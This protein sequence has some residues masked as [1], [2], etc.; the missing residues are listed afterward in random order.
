M[1]TTQERPV[2]A[3]RTKVGGK[4][5]PSKP[6]IV[7][8]TTV[9]ENERLLNDFGRVD[10]ESLLFKGVPPTNWILPRVIADGRYYI[11]GSWPKSGKSVL[12]FDI[13]L[14]LALRRLPMIALPD[15][16]SLVGEE[17][18]GVL[19]L[20]REN[21]LNDVSI[22]LRHLEATTNLRN[23]NYLWHPKLDSLDT[24]EGG[25][26]LIQLVHA[27]NAK[28]VV[29]D[30]ISKFCAGEENYS[31]TWKAFYNYCVAPLKAQGVTIWGLDHLGK[32]R[33]LGL[34]GSS[35]KFADVD[36]LWVLEKKKTY[37]DKSAD[38]V[39]SLVDQRGVNHAEEVHIHRSVPLK[40]DVIAVLDEKGQVVTS[41]KKA[42]SQ[43]M[44][45][46]VTIL[47]DNGDRQIGRVKAKDLF[48]ENGFKNPPERLVREALSTYK[49]DDEQL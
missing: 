36:G 28:F 35:A 20:D 48:V 4:K 43:A 33:A 30:V 34:R 10:L 3:L 26:Q 46:M 39:L 41:R 8:L 40:H 29:I 13:A 7:N 19:Y 11:I 14:K 47:R 25:D 5:V 22:W 38:L 45:R 24:K 16:D 6:Y 32:N 2:G 31:S 17:H 15:D 23:F 9:A 44:A 18:N 37:P 21:V 1:T 49:N 27:S 12:S 42:T